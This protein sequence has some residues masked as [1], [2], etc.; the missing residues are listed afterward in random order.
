MQRFIPEVQK[1]VYFVRHGQSKDN[2]APV[3]QSDDSSLSEHG[4]T[5]AERIAE[6]VS[7]LAFDALIS[8]PLQRARETAEA[9]ERR[10][11]IKPEYSVLFRER[12]NPTSIQGKAFADEAASSLWEASNE[13]LYTSGLRVEDGENY[14]D[15]IARADEALAF[16]SQRT[17]KTLVVVTHGFFLRALVIRVLLRDMLTDVVF[18]NMRHF[19]IMENTGLTI[20]K[21]QNGPES[22]F[23]WRLWI[24]ND[25]AHLAD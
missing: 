10:T 21:Y 6:R 14:D 22:D 25:H 5:Q 24:Y 3:F 16:L 11:T 13:T 20:L 1:T 2:I 8:S 17:E 9:I 15:L 7:H 19:M 12:K 23:A 4:L 18:R